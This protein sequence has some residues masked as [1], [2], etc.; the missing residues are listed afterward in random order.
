[1]E[2]RTSIVIAHRLA[3]IQR[4]NMIFVI[5]D[6]TIVQQG[7]HDELIRAGGLYA[8]LYQTQFR[9]QEVEVLT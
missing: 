3:T 9:Q 1:M 2:G 5:D 8:H 7:T 6:G 4:A